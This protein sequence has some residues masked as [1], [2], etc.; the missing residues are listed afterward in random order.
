MNFADLMV[1]DNALPI[2]W[3]YEG[4]NTQ[5]F[6]SLGDVYSGLLV[7][8][9]NYAHTDIL[10]D[11]NHSQLGATS[12]MATNDNYIKVASQLLYYSGVKVL[13][14]ADGTMPLSN[15]M[16]NTQMNKLLN[17]FE[18]RI[19]DGTLDGIPLSDMNAELIAYA[20]GILQKRL[21]K[22]NAIIGT[23]L[24]S[25]DS[26]NTLYGDDVKNFIDAM[27]KI[28]ASLNNIGAV[29]SKEQAD[30][31]K[32]LKHEVSELNKK[33]TSL[34]KKLDD[35]EKRNE[36]N[37]KKVTEN[38][39]K[40]I[41]KLE[42]KNK[43]LSEKV[44]ALTKNVSAVPSGAKALEK[45][46]D[47]IIGMLG[48]DSEKNAELISSA[49]KPFIDQYSLM[50]TEYDQLKNKAKDVQAQLIDYE[51]KLQN[52]YMLISTDRGMRLG[53]DIA[54]DFEELYAKLNKVADA[55]D[56]GYVAKAVRQFINTFA[57]A[58]DE[59]NDVIVTGNL[60]G[61][62]GDWFEK[63]FGFDTANSAQRRTDSKKLLQFAIDNGMIKMDGKNVAF[64]SDG[65]FTVVK[66][67]KALNIVQLAELADIINEI[68][69]NAKKERDEY[70]ANRD[71]QANDIKESIIKNLQEKHKNGINKGMTVSQY[72]QDYRP[73]SKTSKLLSIS[74]HFYNLA[75]EF[76]LASVKLREIDSDAFYALFFGGLSEDSEGVK[77]LFTQDFNTLIEMETK[78]I[79]DRNGKFYDKV[80]EVFGKYEQFKDKM[81]K[82]GYNGKNVGTYFYRFFEDGDVKLKESTMDDLNEFVKKKTGYDVIDAVK[83]KSSEEIYVALVDRKAPKQI[84]A[85]A[86]FLAEVN[87]EI[88]T[89]EGRI[90]K[91]DEELDRFRTAGNAGIT[92]TDDDNKKV[93]ELNEEKKKLTARIEQYKLAGTNSVE[94]TDNYSWKDIMGIYLMAQQK[95]GF[96]K[97]LSSPKVSIDDD[98]NIELDWSNTVTNN[99]TY[100]NIIYVMTNMLSE[101]GEFVPYREIADFMQ[102]DIGSRYDVIDRVN[103]ITTGRAME[104]NDAYFHFMSDNS[105]DNVNVFGRS[106]SLKNYEQFLEGGVPKG[107]IEDRQKNARYHLNLDAVS[108]YLRSIDNQEHYIALAEKIHYMN[109][110]LG[111]DGSEIHNALKLA[112]GEADGNATFNM[113]TN[114]VGNIA[115]STNINSTASSMLELLNWIR[116]NSAVAKLCGSMTSGAKQFTAYFLTADELGAKNIKKYGTEFISLVWA[117]RDNLEKFMEDNIYKYSSQMKDR[118]MSEYFMYRALEKRYG[119][120]NASFRELKSRITDS[121][122]FGVGFLKTTDTLVANATWYAYFRYFMDNN[123]LGMKE[124]LSDAEYV[125]LCANEATQKTLD[126]SP[127]Q[128]AKNNAEV[129]MSDENTLKTMF[130]FKGQSNKILNKMYGSVLSA[131]M[132]KSTWKDVAKTFGTIYF[133]SVLTS[134]LSGYW[135]KAT[136]KDEDGKVWDDRLKALFLGGLLEQFDILPAVGDFVKDVAMGYKYQSDDFGSS[137]LNLIST[138]KDDDATAKQYANSILKIISSVADFA[139]FG[140]NELLRIYRT[141]VNGN[142]LYM[143]NTWY[144]NLFEGLW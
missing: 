8:L 71:K 77:Q 107:F 88:K 127:S 56:N 52:E 80:A 30:T 100:G 31:I 136:D 59:E 114:L 79:L 36:A 138:F 143:L 86:Q 139:G 122:I 3:K 13:G 131:E 33:N 2:V 61:I 110:I 115:N 12:F 125:Q 118:E 42:E 58:S 119:V 47:R 51:K 124:E 17:E 75:S 83:T 38:S 25:I 15:Y 73:S 66:S 121:N 101:E 6:K 16:F 81:P 60:T 76:E 27:D 112:L 144:A 96:Y 98:Y 19:N 90:E 4:G 50:K 20:R 130:L 11:G 23:V 5:Q 72:G 87:A 1:D 135:A 103:Y 69:E 64:N 82:E 24:D 22:G 133:V 63:A 14:T 128:G 48:D 28:V 102:E 84:I 134:A 37:L 99:L 46:I 141:I 94:N 41:L 129:F 43:A 97:L 91:I 68:A 53:S 49:I 106:V 132:G 93:L 65:S 92:L 35:T 123:Y 85:L 137:L 18:N 32:N 117:N 126:I 74:N 7:D 67:Y 78:N 21:E 62:F 45:S 140:G 10:D 26:I 116:A 111:E 120:K 54:R 108:N 113:L 55:T 34:E 40:N 9:L 89:A 70:I 57:K 105:Y 29:D 104:K 39:E 95:D 44:N 109:S 142:P